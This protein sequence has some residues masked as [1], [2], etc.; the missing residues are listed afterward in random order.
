MVRGKNLEAIRDKLRIMEG[1]PVILKE[2]GRRRSTVKNGTIS[3][4]YGSVF[5]VIVTGMEEGGKLCFTYSDLLT[6]SVV[7]EEEPGRSII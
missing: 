5:T 7:L 3:D 2:T 6:K 1:K 4:V